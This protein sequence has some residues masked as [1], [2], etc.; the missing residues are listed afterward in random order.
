MEQSR[1]Q[2]RFET[3]SLRPRDGIDAVEQFSDPRSTQRGQVVNAGVIGEPGLHAELPARVRLLLVAQAVPFVD[4]EDQGLARLPDDPQQGL[5]LGGN[6]LLGVQH[7]HGDLAHFNGLQAFH[8]AEFLH[9]VR[10]LGAPPDPGR[11]DERVVSLPALKRY[12]DA[13]AGG[14]RGVRSEHPLRADHAVDQG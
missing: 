1:E 9:L 7:Q 10:D 2:R 6:Q 13:V 12:Q 3:L 5:V 14:A 11:V 8:D 4:G